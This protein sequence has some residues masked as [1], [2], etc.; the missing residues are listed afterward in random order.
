MLS[1]ESADVAAAKIV[2][3]LVQTQDL[4]PHNGHCGG[5]CFPGG[6][7]GVVKER[8]VMVLADLPE[9]DRHQVLA[10]PVLSKSR[11]LQ[12]A[13][14]GPTLTESIDVYLKDPDGFRRR[15]SLLST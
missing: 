9:A 12:R 15:S 8:I 7:L 5:R 2:N 11:L 14:S 1:S 4:T 3:L 6:A 10:V 13:F